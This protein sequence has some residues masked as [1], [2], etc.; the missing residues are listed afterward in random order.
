MKSIFFLLAF[1]LNLIAQRNYPALLDKYMQ[2]VV[3]INNYYGNVLIAKGGRIIY[4]KSFGYK[5]FQAKFPLDN[6]SMFEIGMVTQQ[7]TAVAILL[8]AERNE[9]KVTDE[10]TTYFPELP[11]KNITLWH[12]LTSTSGLPEFYE[13]VVKGRWTEKRLA[14]NADMIHYL[15]RENVPLHF[16]PGQ[17]YEPTGTGFALLAS[18]IE[19]ISGLSYQ[20]FLQQHIFNPLQLKNTAV[21]LGAHAHKTDNGGYAQAIAYDEIA[22]KYLPADSLSSAF[23]AFTPNIIAITDSV[24][25]IA[26][27]ITTA[28]DL[29]LW[30]RA[31]KNNTLLNPNTQKEMFAR[32]VLI[33]T[34]SQIFYGYGTMV[35]KNELGS[36]VM[37]QE[38]GNFSL[39]FSTSMMRY[40]GEDITIIVLS[41]KAK[42]GLSQ[43]IGGALSYILYN[44]EVVPLYIHKEVLI[45][46]FLLDRYVG[47]YSLPRVIELVKKDGKLYRRLAGTADTELKPESPTKFFYVSDIADA[48]LEFETNNDGKVVKA[49]YIE[50]GLK[51]EIKKL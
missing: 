32:Q 27:I 11:Y 4:E 30:D 41:N 45:D 20:N 28:A 12:L 29:L 1:P 10:I 38:L 44:R 37:S 34:P 5:D 48:Q 17:K 14:S 40:T 43:R 21:L 50:N 13:E 23:S 7:F 39:G 16:T 36:Y 31:L 47:K 25:G 24:A 9:L 46:T 26:N 18:V 51:K 3:E 35:G 33:D 6:N 42:E 2:S 22:R 49:Y 15:S 8:L 19:K